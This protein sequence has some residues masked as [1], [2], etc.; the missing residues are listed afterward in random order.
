MIEIYCNPGSVGQ[1]RDGDNRAGYASIE[2]EVVLHRYLDIDR[3][4]AIM[5]S[6]GYEPFYYEVYKGQIGRRID[7]IKVLNK[8]KI[9]K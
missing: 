1:P 4:V 9:S 7:Q 2:E 8:G 6:A 5:K 3:T